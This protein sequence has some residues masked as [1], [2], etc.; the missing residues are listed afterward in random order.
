M[1][2]PEPRPAGRRGRTRIDGERR[3]DLAKR[4]GQRRGWSSG[5]FS[6]YGEDTVKRYQTFLATW[7]PAGG[8]SRVVPVDEPDGRSRLLLHRPRGER[9][10]PPGPGGRS[11]QPGERFS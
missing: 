6:L 4:A 8:V 11:V 7:R 10:R 3:I 9:G 1:T 5:T 2:L